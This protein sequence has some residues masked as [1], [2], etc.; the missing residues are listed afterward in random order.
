[1]SQF[2]HD[3]FAKDLLENLLSPFGEVETNTL[4]LLLAG[5]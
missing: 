4:I 5:A 3:Q 1:M 2:P